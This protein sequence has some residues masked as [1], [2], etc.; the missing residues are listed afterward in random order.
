MSRLRKSQTDAHHPTK[1]ARFRSSISFTPEL[2]VRVVSGSKIQT[3]RPVRPAGLEPE[4][5]D[6]ATCPFGVV[7]DRIAVLEKWSRTPDGAILYAMGCPHDTPR[8]PWKAARFMPRS[9]TRHFLEVLFVRVEKLSSVS[10]ADARA[11]GFESRDAF[12]QAWDAIY[13]E[14]DFRSGDNPCVWVIDFSASSILL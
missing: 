12:L 4:A 1:Q 2:L 7:R 14:G 5:I 10:E 8:A 11:E 9:A 13:G 3:R 6:P